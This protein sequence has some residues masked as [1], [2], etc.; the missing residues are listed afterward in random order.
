M[1]RKLFLEIAKIAFHKWRAHNSLLRAAALAYFVI[2]PLPLLLLI[3]LGIL[4]LIYGQAEAFKALIQQITTVAGSSVAE[5]IQQLLDATKTPFTSIFASITSIVF[6]AA[7]AIGI[8]GVLQETMNAIWEV[9]QPKP[10]LV[11]R[12]KR[13]IIPFLLVSTIG[14]AIM[15]WTGISTVL[16]SFITLALDPFAS[17]LIG[18]I[19]RITHIG[20]SFILATL[21]FAIIYKQ[22]PDLAIQWK[23]VGLAATI[24]GLIFTITNYLFGIII[25]IFTFTSVTGAAGSLLILLPWIFMINLFILYGAAFSKVYAEKIG[26]YS[27]K[28]TE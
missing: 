16:L 20:L 2:L 21:L 19:L 11:E 3:I 4:A 15:I 7:G 10:S 27:L 8:F 5:L 13:K 25:E 24:T 22:I 17:N 23:D 9:T 6:T 12:I 14:L 1:D 18:A 26:S 28:Q